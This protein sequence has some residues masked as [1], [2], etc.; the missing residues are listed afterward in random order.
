[1]LSFQDYWSVQQIA[2][3]RVFIRRYRI[4][5][6][7]CSRQ[8]YQRSFPPVSR[9]QFDIFGS[10]ARATRWFPPSAICTNKDQFSSCRRDHLSIRF[11]ALGCIAIIMTVK[12]I[13]L[14]FVMAFHLR[15][16][17]KDLLFSLSLWSK[18]AREGVRIHNFMH[19][20][21]RH[22]TNYPHANNRLSM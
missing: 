8:V 21:L 2:S 1:M 3:R 10:I 17:I 7:Y 14:D 9:I 5:S 4:G 22:T 18:L 13:V 19:R 12:L 16:W 15:R 11:W 20:N 6:Q